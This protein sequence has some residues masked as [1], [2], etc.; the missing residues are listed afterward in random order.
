MDRISKMQKFPT[1]G[2]MLMML[3]L[4]FLVQLLVG[5]VANLCGF[6]APVTHAIGSVDIETYMN[7][8][9]ALGR[10][11]AIFYPVSFLL[12]IGALWLYARLRGGKK[13]IRI[14]HSASG[15]NPT[16]VLVG[17]LWLFSSQIILEPIVALLPE[18]TA[19]GLGRG[20]WACFTAVIT[21]AVLEEL[22]CRGLLFETLNKRWG[23]KTSIFFSALFFGI[24][25]F[26]L[27]TAIVALVAGVIFGVLYVRTSSLYTTII[28]HAINNALAFALI[29]FGVGDMSFKEVVGG[30]TLYYILYGVAVAIFVACSVEAYF[31]VFKTKKANS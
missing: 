18:N 3:L 17:V 23:V 6:V 11:I 30:G 16:I 9:E 31:K 7:E 4:F 19:Q 22:L 24:I 13:V 29:S 15:F 12:S 27:A 26:D 14:R 25:H 10:Y 20:I 8:Q 28:I 5:V 1:V 2:D 21:A